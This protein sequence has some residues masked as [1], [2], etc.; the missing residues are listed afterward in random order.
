MCL[1]RPRSIKRSMHG[2]K[3]FVKLRTTKLVERQ[4]LLAYAILFKRCGVQA[5]CTQAF[6]I[7][8]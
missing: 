4:S 5:V 7:Q 6:T 3:H 2:S 8:Y 1:T